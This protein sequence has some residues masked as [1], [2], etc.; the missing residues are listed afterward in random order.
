MDF[1][2]VKTL[3]DS[4]DTDRGHCGEV[5]ESQ[6]SELVILFYTRPG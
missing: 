2:G 3:E 6:S 4:P 1:C 5:E